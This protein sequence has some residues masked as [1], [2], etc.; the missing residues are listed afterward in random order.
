MEDKTHL[1][2]IFKPSIRELL[3]TANNM[4]I[5]KKDIVDVLKEEGQ[6]FM[7]FETKK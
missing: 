1:D 6:F 2:A 5:H 7:I 3:E 4:G